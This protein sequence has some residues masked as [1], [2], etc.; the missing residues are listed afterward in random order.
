MSMLCQT[1]TVKK[2]VSVFLYSGLRQCLLIQV[3]S[4][5]NGIIIAV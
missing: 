4:E 3:N 5:R 1:E 2:T